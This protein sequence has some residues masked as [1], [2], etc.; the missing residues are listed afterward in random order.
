MKSFSSLLAWLLLIAVLAVPSFL[1]YNW[2][3]KSKQQT[4][5]EITPG[6]ATTNVFSADKGAAHAPAP[7]AG[8]ERAP[9]QPASEP[10]AQKPPDGLQARQAQ[11]AAQTPAERQPPVSAE[12][13]EPD[14]REAEKEE[15]QAEPRQAKE[16]GRDQP[17]GE[18]ALEASTA[19]KP[20]SYYE[21]KSTRD[22]TLT[23]DDYRRIKEARRQREEAER[24]RA[25]AERNRPKPA[26]PETLISLQGIIGDAAIVNGDMYKAGQK[27]RGIKILKIGSNYILCEY[28]GKRFRKV[29]R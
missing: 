22:P 12:A 1:F 11:A 29:M 24:M 7:A 15:P 27:V 10:A 28:Q 26:G 17:A 13:P 20:V 5:S 3:S 2:W 19:P 4:S 8:T 14:M 25:L 16:A 6:P 23:P 9:A 21:P 18:Q